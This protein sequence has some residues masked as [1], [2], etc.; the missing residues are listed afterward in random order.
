MPLTLLRATMDEA[1]DLLAWRND[2]VTRAQSRHGDEIGWDDHCRWLARVTDDPDCLFLIGRVDGVR[3]GFVRFNRTA[4]ADCWEVSI[5]LAPSW[6]EQGIGGRLLRA[7]IDALRAGN[8]GA[9][10]LAAVRP[11]NQAS[12][13]LFRRSGFQSVASAEEF[14]HFRLDA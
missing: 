1:A 11:G 6:R 12:E 13:A 14:L 8:P 10:V 4:A 5:A 3:C 2:A 7:G 9:R